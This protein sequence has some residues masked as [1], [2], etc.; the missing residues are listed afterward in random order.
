MI[1]IFINI[2]YQLQKLFLQKL[3]KIDLLNALLKRFKMIK[4]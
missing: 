4:V 3:N 2:K 1:M